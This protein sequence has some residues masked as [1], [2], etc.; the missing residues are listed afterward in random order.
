MY[1]QNTAIAKQSAWMEAN[2]RTLPRPAEN[3]LL[4]LFPIFGPVVVM[5]LAS[6]CM[7]LLCL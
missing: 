3:S 4:I 7:G 5:M 2:V 6:K 1:A